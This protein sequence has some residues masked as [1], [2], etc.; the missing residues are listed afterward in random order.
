MLSTPSR[1]GRFKMQ[2]NLGESWFHDPPTPPPPFPGDTSSAM[3]KRYRN[4]QRRQ[5]DS[6]QR[7]K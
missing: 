2:A 7:L 5:L 6:F 4:D 3:F 1:D